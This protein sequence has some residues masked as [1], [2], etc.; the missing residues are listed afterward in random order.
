[1]AILILPK[2]KILN[3]NLPLWVP[4]LSC[5]ITGMGGLK[6]E[7]QWPSV[8]LCHQFQKYLNPSTPYLPQSPSHPPSSRPG[9]PFVTV[10]PDMTQDMPL[11]PMP[12]KLPETTSPQTSKLPFV[13]R[14]IHYK[15]ITLVRNPNSFLI[16]SKGLYQGPGKNKLTSSSSRGDKWFWP[17]VFVWLWV[18]S[19]AGEEE[20]GGS[21]GVVIMSV[22]KRG[23]EERLHSP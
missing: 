6:S 22:H 2:P 20:N 21:A 5:L 19:S 17:A 23:S 12:T 16:F 13:P 11:Y 4:V 18:C 9:M 8:L 10:I 7:I 15:Q 3:G 14:Q 1:M